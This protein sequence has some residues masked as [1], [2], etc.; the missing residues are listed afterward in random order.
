MTSSE[1]I[2]RCETCGRVLVVDRSALGFPPEGAKRKL[3]KLCAADGHVA[4]PV[5][6]AGFNFPD[7]RSD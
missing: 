2:V 6:R 5:Y 4:T 7:W 1:P 3:I